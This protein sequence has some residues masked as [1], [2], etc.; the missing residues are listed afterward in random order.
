MIRTPEESTITSNDTKAQK[1]TSQKSIDE[2]WTSTLSYL[3]SHA[4]F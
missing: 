1:W 4:M 2:K 3:Q